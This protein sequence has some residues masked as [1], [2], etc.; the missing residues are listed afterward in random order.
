[1][2]RSA[3]RIERSRRAQRGQ[4]SGVSLIEMLTAMAVLVVLMGFLF[5]LFQQSARAWNLGNSRI[6]TFQTSRVVVDRIAQE[7]AIAITRTNVHFRGQDDQIWFVAPVEPSRALSSDLH[8]IGYTWD[9][10]GW[11]VIRHST[12]PDS[13]DWNIFSPSWWSS[14]AT[15][16]LMASNSILDL[17]FTYYDATGSAISPPGAATN[18]PAAVRVT[19]QVLDNRAADQ[20]RM[21]PDNP[22]ITNRY[23]RTFTKLVRLHNAAD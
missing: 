19:I 9:P 12:P 21:V 1:M 8:E 7:L 22:D 5:V 23:L 18:L 15:T 14:M 3:L 11:A 16:R 17:R 20:F 4:C 13:S 2:I 10:L 6:E